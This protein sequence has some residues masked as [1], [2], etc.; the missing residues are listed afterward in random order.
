[1][2]DLFQLTG[3]DVQ[4]QAAAGK[5]KPATIAAMAYSG[6]FMRV[7]TW[8][9]VA[10]DLAGLDSSGPIQILTDHDATLSGV[11]GT[12][13]AEVRGGKLYVSGILSRA[14]EAARQIIALYADGVRFEASVGVEPGKRDFIPEG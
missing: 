12:G 4:I 10:L 6:G 5:A 13:Q 3:G 14:S 9:V 8:G 7:P 2:A 1:M 11:L